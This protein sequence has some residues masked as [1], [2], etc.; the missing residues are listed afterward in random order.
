MTKFLVE[1]KGVN[2]VR[3]LLNHFYFNR[4][5][6]RKRV[7]MYTPMGEEHARRIRALKKFIE[8]EPVLQDWFDRLEKYLDSFADKCERGFYEQVKGV[9]LFQFDGTDKNGLNLWIR[10][11]GSTRAENVHQKM[12]VAFG[13]WSIGAQSGH[14]LLQLVSLRYNVS[15]GIRRCNEP[16]FGHP[17]LQFIDRIDNRLQEIY[18][19]SIFMRHINL[20]QFRHVENFVSVGIGPLFYDERFVTKGEPNEILSG[21]AHFVA[22]QMGV[23]CAP[24]GFSKSMPKERKIFN[25]FLEKHPN[26]SPSQ[27]E[28]LAAVFLQE[29]NCK[30][31][32]PKL[33]SMLKEYHKRWTESRLIIAKEEAMKAGYDKLLQELAVPASMRLSR[34][35]PEIDREDNEPLQSREEGGVDASSLARKLPA[36][37][38]A[39]PGQRNYVRATEE[40]ES[41]K[42]P[43]VAFTGPSVRKV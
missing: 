22:K 33:P 24:R 39:A 4:E 25:D 11:R 6:W 27:F 20:S 32:F 5:W 13:P 26:P 21:D 42:R 30:T 18:G 9:E 29:T 7:R 28:E 38:I 41:S 12:R 16:D 31:V 2:T 34:A 8:N 36:P 3:D 14:Y 1:S 23:K 35:A 37:P 17:W 15:T 40:S 19:R 43:S 10:M